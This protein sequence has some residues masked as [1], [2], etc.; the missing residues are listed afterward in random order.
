MRVPTTSAAEAPAA[1]RKRAIE[2]PPGPY[3]DFDL[4]ASFRRARV[5]LEAVTRDLAD[6]R[7]RAAER[8]KPPGT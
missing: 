3:P 6:L 1:T 2:R 5:G 4:A 8:S 7:H